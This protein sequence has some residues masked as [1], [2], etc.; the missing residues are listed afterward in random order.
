MTT[1]AAPLEER[2]EVTLPW[3]CFIKSELVGR[4]PYLD[5]DDAKLESAFAHERLSIE[6]WKATEWAFI[7]KELKEFSFVISEDIEP[8]WVSPARAVLWQRQTTR[9]REVSEKGKVKF[10]DETTGW[11]PTKGQPIGNA[12]QLAYYF[13]KGLRLRPPQDGVEDVRHLQDIEATSP[14]E[15]LEVKEPAKYLDDRL[16]TGTIGFDTWKGYLRHC[17]RHKLTPEHEPPDEIKRT[18][19]NYEYFDVLRNKGFVNRKSAY[20]HA[21][22]IQRKT[23]MKAEVLLKS[24]KVQ[25]DKKDSNSYESDKESLGSN[26]SKLSDKKAELVTEKTVD[27][28]EEV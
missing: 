12:S 13:R 22:D 4:N 28:V 25:Y 10:V 23:G 8:H 15:P 26:E 16:P 2:S 11:S 21:K 5:D 24:F 9:K 17:E 14:A 7:V 18:M 6:H 19:L 1:T 27:T 3:D 20:L